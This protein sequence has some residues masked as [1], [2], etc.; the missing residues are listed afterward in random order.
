MWAFLS[1]KTMRVIFLT[2]KLTKHTTMSNEQ[3]IEET[4]RYFT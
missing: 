4:R 1:L 3:I 2:E